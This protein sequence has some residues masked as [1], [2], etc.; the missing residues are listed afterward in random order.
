[1]RALEG[2][3]TK[4]KAGV[5]DPRY[6]ALQEEVERL[7]ALVAEKDSEIEN[8]LKALDGAFKRGQAEGRTAALEE[9]AADRET[10][11]E[12][13]EAA[14]DRSLALLER[15]LSS[16]ERLAVVVASESLEKI[17]EAP[18][19]FAEM[20]TQIIRK[21]LGRLDKAAI[22]RIEVSATDFIDA[23]RNALSSQIG[24][25]TAEIRLC[26]DL[27][28]GD[29]RIRMALGTLDIGLNQQWSQLKTLLQDLS[30]PG[31]EP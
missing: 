31:A 29:C 13:L 6:A 25:P 18:G 7:N 24:A 22:V 17:L 11:V 21:Q 10:L 20:A 5:V 26:D 15:E 3:S 1:V 8:G 28:S 12:S 27:A 23:D 30:E 16:M 2:A 14:V 9:T 19:A 4:A